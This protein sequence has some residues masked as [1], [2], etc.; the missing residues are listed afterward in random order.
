M[1]AAAI[2]NEGIAEILIEKGANLNAINDFGD[3]ALNLAVALSKN[4]L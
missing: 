3:S 4:R 1:M 2:G